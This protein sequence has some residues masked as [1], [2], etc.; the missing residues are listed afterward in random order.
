VPPD[1]VPP[2][3]VAADLVAAADAGKPQPPTKLRYGMN[4]DPANPKGNPAAKTLKAAGVRWVRIE[5]KSSKG[6]ALYDPLI[7]AHRAAGLKVLLL[8]DYASVPG[9][10]ASDASASQWTAYLALFDKGLAGIAKHYGNGV[11]AWQVWN[12]PDL[13]KQ[14]GYDPG[15]PAAHFGK[16]L[17]AAVKTI[18]LHSTRPVIGGGLAS[19]STSYVAAAVKAAGPLTVDA[20]AVHPYGQRAPDDWPHAGWGFGNMSSLLKAYLAL[21]KPVWI[22]EIGTDVTSPSTFQADYLQNVYLLAK[23]LGKQVPVV[24]WFCWSDGMVSPYGVLDAQGKP[25]PAHARYEKLAGAW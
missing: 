23:Q 15:V 9:K 2:D 20:L 8:V 12:E 1:L 11:D 14:P 4:I 7:A 17:A 3:L 5:Y 10:P 18:G 24:F 13:P 21:G 19:G 16:L 25:K 6:Y 22:S